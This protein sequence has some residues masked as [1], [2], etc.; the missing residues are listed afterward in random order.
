MTPLHPRSDISTTQGFGNSL[1]RALEF[2]VTTVVF[3]LLGWFVDRWAGT[4]PV[5]VIALTVLSLAGQFA[6]MYYAYDAEMNAHA[7]LLPGRADTSARP[8]ANPTV[9]LLGD[10][11]VGR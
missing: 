7:A 2:A 5:F 3:S 1:S 8:G 6:R 4:E 11:E 10:G 9:D